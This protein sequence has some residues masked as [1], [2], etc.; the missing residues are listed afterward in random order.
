MQTGRAM[1]WYATT[2]CVLL[3]CLALADEKVVFRCDFD[4]AIVPGSEEGKLVVGFKG[5]QALL[6]EQAQRGFYSQRFPIGSDQ[7]DDRF[8]T[9]RAVVK[10]EDV[11]KPPNAWNGS[12]EIDARSVC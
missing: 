2:L 4:K 11:S 6:I 3:A 9:L 8:A 7:F 12:R 10:T 1:N 5:S